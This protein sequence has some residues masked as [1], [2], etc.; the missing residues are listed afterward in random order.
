[1]TNG[2]DGAVISKILNSCVLDLAPIC[3]T[4]FKKGTFLRLREQCLM[5]ETGILLQ[6]G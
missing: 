3:N 2:G 4:Y 5:T 6:G 1:M